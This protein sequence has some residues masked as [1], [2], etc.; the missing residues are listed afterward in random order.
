V[1]VDN[2]G[3]EGA[4]VEVMLYVQPSLPPFSISSFFFLFRFMPYG[5]YLCCDKERSFFFH[6]FFFHKRSAMIE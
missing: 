6:F 2:N 1:V 5:L 3:V 4:D